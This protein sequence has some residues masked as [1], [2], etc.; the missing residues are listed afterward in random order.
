SYM[1]EKKRGFMKATGIKREVIIILLMVLLTLTAPTLY[2]VQT[3]SQ[4][5]SES[6]EL[7]SEKHKGWVTDVAFSPD[8]RRVLSGSWDT[9]AR[10]WDLESS[11]EIHTFIGHT[12]RVYCVDLSRNGR[13]ALT[14]SGDSTVR[15]WDVE[16]GIEI[17]SFIEQKIPPARVAFSPDS[18]SAIAVD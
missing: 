7:N 18:R 2:S 15:L 13:F 8:G 14:G 6:G 4:K 9:T 11:K 16:K 3:A 5:R 12:D 1:G 10:L 17:R